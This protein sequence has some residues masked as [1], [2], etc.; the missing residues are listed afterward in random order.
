MTA[1][2][3]LLAATELANL[4][5]GQTEHDKI[6]ADQQAD[7]GAH[8]DGNNI[9]LQAA[10]AQ[11]DHGAGQS[12]EHAGQ[13]IRGNKA[14]EDRTKENNQTKQDAN[15]AHSAVSLT[16]SGLK[17]ISLYTFIPAMSSSVGR[18]SAQGNNSRQARKRSSLIL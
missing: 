12:G 18:K 15:R 11:S 10:G 6:Q 14:E 7:K 9:D 3:F 1:D 16:Y 17:S 13:E 8:A 4:V 5:V 2:M